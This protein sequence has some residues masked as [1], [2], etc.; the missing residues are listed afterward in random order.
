[1]A[2]ESTSTKWILVSGTGKYDLPRSEYLLAK[3]LGKAIVAAGYGLVTGGWIGVDHVVAASFSE[4]LMKLRKPLSNYL[5][6]VVPE[7]QEPDF[8]GGYII[9]VPK[10][11]K[12]WIESVRYADAVILLGGVGGTYET[13]LFALQEQKPIFPIASTEGDARKS[14]TDIVEHWDAEPLLA[15]NVND[16]K[17]ILSQPVHSENDAVMVSNNLLN[18]IKTNLSAMQV[19]QEVKNKRIFISYSHRDKEWLQTVRLMLKPLERQKSMVIWDDTYIETGRKWKDEIDK[20]LTLSNIAIFLV[21]AN[22]IASDFIVANELPPLLQK[23]STNGVKIF[24]ILVSSG[25]YDV[26]GLDKYQ[27]A[28]DISKPLDLLS[29]PEQKQVLVE[30]T[31]K[32]R[33]ALE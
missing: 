11:P 5:M 22:F 33:T 17:N 23:A 31:K 28:H 2:F 26:T 14:F 9:T 16:Y 6:Q 12:E 18:L 25:L 4:E 21:S 30:I 27:A 1:M 7:G 10:G 3:E 32:I 15:I 20:A 24:W 19:P 13:H 8:K 29:P